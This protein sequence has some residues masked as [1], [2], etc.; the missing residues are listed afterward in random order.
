MVNKQCPF[1]VMFLQRPLFENFSHFEKESHCNARGGRV[2]TM[3]TAACPTFIVS[4]HTPPRCSRRITASA[5]LRNARCF[6][7]SLG[8][9]P[10][11]S[12]MKV[13]TCTI[14]C[15]A[16]GCVVHA[17]RTCAAVHMQPQ[18]GPRTGLSAGAPLA[19]LPLAVQPGVLS[20]PSPISF[21]TS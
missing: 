5:P 11:C 9:S 14:V 8:Q 19:L 3:N 7:V 2:W 6:S 15:A 17:A 20:L 1:F 12:A 16:S 21:R 4:P 13:Q 10:P 18:V